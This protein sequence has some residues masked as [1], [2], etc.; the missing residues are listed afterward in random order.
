MSDLGTEHSTTRTEAESPSLFRCPDH[1]PPSSRRSFTFACSLSDAMDDGGINSAGHES[2]FFRHV[3]TNLLTVVRLSGRFVDG[4]GL[5]A[6]H[7]EI[8]LVKLW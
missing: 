5:H 1:H 4:G 2:T 8:L 3:M 7:S 6:L